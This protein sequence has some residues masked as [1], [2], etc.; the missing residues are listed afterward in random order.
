MSTLI[1]VRI[2]NRIRGLMVVHCNVV[3]WALKAVLTADGISQQE[4]VQYS[5]L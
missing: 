3:E 1:V 5:N 2:E 4:L